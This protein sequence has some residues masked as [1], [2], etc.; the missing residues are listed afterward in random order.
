MVSTTYGYELNLILV[1]YDSDESIFDENGIF[2]TIVRYN[3]L[4]F[5]RNLDYDDYYETI[6]VVHKND[7]N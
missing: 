5:Y 2:N 7:D 6:N 3:A 4:K 1:E